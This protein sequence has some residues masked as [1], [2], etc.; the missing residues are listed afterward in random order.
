MRACLSASRS[1]RGVKPA[2]V[3]NR[4]RLVV[5]SAPLPTKGSRVDLALDRHHRGC[6]VGR[7][8]LLRPGTLLPVAAPGELDRQRAAAELQSACGCLSSRSRAARS[9]MRRRSRADTRAT[10]RISRRRS[11]GRRRD[12]T[13]RLPAG[14]ARA[15]PRRSRGGT[16]SAQAATAGRAR[17]SATTSS[18]RLPPVRP[19]RRRRPGLRY[20]HSQV[21]AGDR[22][23]PPGDGRA[24]GTH[25]R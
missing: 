8:W 4:G 16:P 3:A 12:S 13:T 25:G 18:L 21:G 10:A 23:A 1:H 15:R 17:R 7:P 5:E 22:G 14:W 20:G 11:A 9:G 6:R 24:R 19:R 2:D